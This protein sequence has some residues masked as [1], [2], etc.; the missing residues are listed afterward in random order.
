MSC[1][2]ERGVPPNATKAEVRTPS[3]VTGGG[4]RPRP[5][6][7]PRLRTMPSLPNLTI[8]QHRFFRDDPTTGMVDFENSVDQLAR[9]IRIVCRNLQVRSA[10]FEELP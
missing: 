3:F 7:V 9:I 10:W 2:T 4:A 6:G 8:Q 5:N 1:R